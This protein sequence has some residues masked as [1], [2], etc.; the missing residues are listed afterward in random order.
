M[1]ESL[2][3]LIPV[4]SVNIREFKFATGLAT[5]GSARKKTGS[6]YT[7]DSLVQL[8][9]NTTL[10]PVLDMAQKRSSA[11]PVG[12]ILK[13]SIIDPACGSG[14]FLLGAARRVAER[15]ARLRSPDA[16]SSETYQHAIR[17]VV[18]HCIFGVDRNPMAVELC[19]VAL[20]IEALEPG[21]PLSYLDARIRCGDS[22]VGV[23]DL[24]MLVEGLPN[25]AF[26]ALAG[27]DKELAK[28]LRTKNTR[29]R[30]SE[31]ATGMFEELRAPRRRILTRAQKILHMPEDTLHQATAKKIAWEQMLDDSSRL[32]VRKACDMYVAAFF[33]PKT[34]ASL[35]TRTC[36]TTSF[37]WNTLRT[38]E[39]LREDDLE[40]SNI[41]TDIRAFHWPLEFPSVMLTGGFD[42][43][44]GNPPWE[45]LKNTGRRILRFPERSDRNSTESGLNVAD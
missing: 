39:Y 12:E 28:G 7:P 45:R 15:I 42:V 22:L 35:E 44:I 14:H 36:P 30:I 33:I 32:A 3:E 4:V 38:Q 19:R 13:L 10:D 20:W 18:T 25:D 43:V 24:Q 41:S 11:D 2:L 26:H 6:Y 8:L 9:L 40:L 37:V 17:E 16:P 21:K 1:Y 31:F 27:D 34:K 5:K 23:F 29:E